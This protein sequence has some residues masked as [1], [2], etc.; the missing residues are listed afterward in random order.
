MSGIIEIKLGGKLRTLQFNNWQKEALGKLYGVDPLEVATK[1]AIAW[2]DSL[3]TV[4]CDLAYTAMVGDYRVRR[5]PLDFTIDDVYAW[6]ADASNEDMAKVLEGWTSTQEVRELIKHLSEDNEDATPK[7]KP[8][9]KKL[10]T[11]P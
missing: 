2:A 9:G 3:L 8:R 6:A 11:S 7:K 1:F 4:S 10:K 5:Q